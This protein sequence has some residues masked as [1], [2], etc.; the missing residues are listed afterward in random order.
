MFTLTPALNMVTAVVVLTKALV[1]GFLSSNLQYN[2]KYTNCFFSVAKQD[3][4]KNVDSN[5]QHDYLPKTGENSH[6]F[7]KT[8]FN[9]NLNCIEKHKHLYENLAR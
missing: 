6:K 7:E 3:D 1:S 8:N 9:G 5:A 2:R 4:D